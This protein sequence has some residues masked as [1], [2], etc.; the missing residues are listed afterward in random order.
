MRRNLEDLKSYGIVLTV[1]SNLCHKLTKVYESSFA[2]SRE[3]I[4]KQASGN[5]VSE[6]KAPTAD[7]DACCCKVISQ[8]TG[9][10]VKIDKN[11]VSRLDIATCSKAKTIIVSKTAVITDLAS[12]EAMKRGIE[13]MRE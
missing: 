4:E 8:E 2:F 13:I 1:N 9:G 6:Q 7:E 5:S 11:V 12:D 10:S 3:D